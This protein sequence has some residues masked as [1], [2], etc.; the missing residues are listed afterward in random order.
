MKRELFIHF[1]IWFSFFVFVTL[2]KHYLNFSYWPFWLGG[3]LG[4]IL[5]DI[6][7]LIYV[8]FV[9]PQDLTSQ[10]V[11]YLVN[12]KEIGRSVELLYE[13]R[14]ERKDLIFHSVFF[15]VIFLILAFWMMS[16]SGSFFG[17]GLVLSFAL[18][19]SVDQIIDLTELKSFD[20]WLKNLPI[21]ISFG[22]AKIY[23]AITILLVCI[24][25]FLL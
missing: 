5:P 17:R 19:L 12:K 6:D 8:Y 3:I 18:H 9:K 20:N 15:Q 21:Y 4:I 1:A 13:T 16:S 24:F 11:G 14:N 23:C 7:H 10:R 22:S 2:V 25:G